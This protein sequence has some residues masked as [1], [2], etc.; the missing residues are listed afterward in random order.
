[1]YQ[2]IKIGQRR[3]RVDCRKMKGAVLSAA[4]VALV[5]A[6]A[7]WFSGWCRCGW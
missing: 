7:V 6:E 4:A 3:Y 2:T 5:I 1:M